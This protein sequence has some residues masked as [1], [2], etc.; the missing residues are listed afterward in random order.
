MNKI[1]HYKSKIGYIYNQFQAVNENKV[2]ILLN[3]LAVVYM[4]FVP[5]APHGYA[6]SFIFTIAYF[7]LFIRGHYFKYIS[8]SLSHP[9]VI[10]FLLMALVHYIWVSGTSDNDFANVTLKYSHYLLYP[11]FFFLFLDQRFYSRL[12]TSF[13]IGVMLSE[14]LSYLMQFNLIPHGYIY[15]L[16]VPWKSSHLAILFYGFMNGEPS[17]FLEHSWYSVLLAVSSSIFFYKGLNSCTRNIKMINFLFFTTISINLFF[18]GGRTGYILYFLLILSI[19]LK[20]TG[21][22]TSLKIIFSSFSVPLIIVFFMYKFGGIFQHR[23]DNTINAIVSMKTANNLSSTSDYSFNDKILKA[24]ASI[25]LISENFLFGVGTGDQLSE[26]RSKPENIN[27][28]IQKYRD[29]HNQYLD[30]FMQFGVIG[31]AFYIYLLYKIAR[32]RIADQEQN[33]LKTVALIAMIFVGFL[34]SFWYFLPILFT[35]LIIISTTDKNIITDKV[36][37]PSS[38]VI[39]GYIS[40]ILLSYTIGILQ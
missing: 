32:Y 12:I 29:V 40:M 37:Q 22:K 15:T 8:S 39:F 27:N 3:H 7:L 36:E 23:I 28:P 1:L 38:K 14:G 31:F 20:T 4:F 24:K 17:P 25:Q 2:N 9:L 10:P 13:L 35:M 26:L 11:F 33:A 30:I 16:H 5:F 18:I 34:G 6:V 21:K 19:I